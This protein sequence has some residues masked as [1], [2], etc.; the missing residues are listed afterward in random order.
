[1]DVKQA[2]N[3]SKGCV[4]ASYMDSGTKQAVVEILS[5]VAIP[6]T[7]TT[8]CKVCSADYVYQEDWR[9]CPNCGRRLEE[10]T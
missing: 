5:S 3:I 6:K 4:M 1:M 2:I 8:T 10:T 9:Y 7:E